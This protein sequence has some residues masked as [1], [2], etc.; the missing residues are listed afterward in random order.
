MKLHKAKC[1]CIGV[2]VEEEF[3][4]LQPCDIDEV[5]SILYTEDVQTIT[6]L[7]RAENLVFRSQQRLKLEKAATIISTFEGF[8]KDLQRLK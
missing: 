3:L 4:V 2:V 6:P 8:Y 1:G 7:T 5:F